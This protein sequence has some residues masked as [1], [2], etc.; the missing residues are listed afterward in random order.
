MAHKLIATMRACNG[1][2]VSHD[3]YHSY[4]ATI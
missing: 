1:S 2:C 3:A 4:C